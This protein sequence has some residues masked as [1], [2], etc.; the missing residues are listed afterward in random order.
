MINNKKNRVGS[1]AQYGPRTVGEILHDFLENSNEPL[2][3]AF[4]NRKVFPNTEFDV[5]LKLLT[6]EPGRMHVG[7]NLN[8]NLT[9]DSRNHYTFRENAPKR[10]GC[11]RYPFVYEGYCINVTRRD[12]GSLYPHFRLPHCTKYY[13][14]GDFCREASEELLMVASL[15][16]E[17]LEV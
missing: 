5:D 8:G 7:A 1:E 16:E 12:D 17:D 2:A 3:V 11:K 9:C 10:K 4:R 13:T 14:F 15:L 6:R